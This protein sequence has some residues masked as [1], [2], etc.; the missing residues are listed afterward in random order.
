[1]K[2]NR[3]TS[4]RRRWVFGVSVV[5]VLAIGI[6]LWLLRSKPANSPMPV[7]RGRTAEQWLGQ[8]AT[9]NRE[10][11][12]SAF[13]RMGVEGIPVLLHAFEKVDSP[14]DRFCQWAYPKLPALVRARMSPPVPAFVTRGSAFMVFLKYDALK[15]NAYPQLLRYLENKDKSEQAKSYVLGVLYQTI[16][17]N[18][19]NAVPVVVTF[20]RANDSD[21]RRVAAMCLERIGTSAKL[22]VPVL[23]G[24]LTDTDVRVRL[25]AASAL[26]RID[27]QTNVATAVFEKE[28][29]LM[30]DSWLLIPTAMKLSEI[31]P[32]SPAL[33][34]AYIK[35][36]Q[37][38]RT[39]FVP[40]D[41][42]LK[43]V[44]KLAEYGGGA[45]AAVPVLLRI[46]KEEPELRSTA[47]QTLSQI[48][49]DAVKERGAPAPSNQ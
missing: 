43:A 14:W 35:G 16:D 26:W 8:L 5:A 44:A 21:S 23:T 31:S 46:I 19:T 32:E 4:S 45:E 41:F 10:T 37:A 38:P 18:S 22:A 20:L 3:L 9:T 34:P 33:L 25:A 15:K 12:L 29:A 1:M 47:L 11:A 17:Q 48:S 42:R 27:H 13:R 2:P 36:L 30:V 49:P 40:A 28:L 7:Y 24:A 39:N 6:A